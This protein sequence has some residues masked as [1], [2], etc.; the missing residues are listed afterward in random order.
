MKIT[1]QAIIGGTIGAVAGA[2]AGTYI[3]NKFFGQKD[4]EV[5]AI[6]DGDI[7]VSPNCSALDEDGTAEEENDTV[8]E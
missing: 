6:C 3:G 5:V 8:A 4:D 7:S 1:K 2:A